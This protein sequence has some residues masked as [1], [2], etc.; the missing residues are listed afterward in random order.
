MIVPCQIFVECTTEQDGTYI[1]PANI[2]NNINNKH[3]KLSGRNWMAEAVF[4]QSEGRETGRGGS[5]SP[6][7]RKAVCGQ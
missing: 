3:S 1:F 4:I 6:Y 2:D 5:I 7:L